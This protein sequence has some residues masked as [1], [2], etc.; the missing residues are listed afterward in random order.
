MLRVTNI[1]TAQIRILVASKL[2]E[3]SH[4]I[5]GIARNVFWCSGLKIVFIATTHSGAKSKIYEQKYLNYSFRC[6]KKY[7][8]KFFKIRGGG[9][10]K[11]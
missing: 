8:V 4:S 2:G 6:K 9:C 5:S 7:E 11:S 10:G 1:I 3:T